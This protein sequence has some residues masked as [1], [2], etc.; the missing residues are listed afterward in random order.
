MIQRKKIM[1]ITID[2]ADAGGQILRTALF[3][4]TIKEKPF[5]ITNIRAKRSNPGLKPQHLCGVE[6]LVKITG[7][8]C[9]AKINDTSLIFYPGK[10]NS[11]KENIDI[12]TAGSITLLLQ[13]IIPVLICSKKISNF[14]ITGG[15]DVN[16]SPSMDYYIEVIAPAISQYAEIRLKILKRG[17][18]PKGSG[19][20]S[21]MIKPT[22]KFESL[23]YNNR[24]KLVQ[25]IGSTI[26]SKELANKEISERIKKSE[27]LHLKEI[28][29]TKSI[30]CAYSDT[31]SSGVITTLVAKYEN[32][33]IGSDVLGEIKVTS[34]EIGKKCANI[35]IER[36]NSSCVCDEHLCDNLIPFVGLFGGEIVTNKVTE[37][38]ITNINVTNQF[39]D[40]GKIILEEKE[41]KIIIKKI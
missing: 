18:Y 8:K 20:I 33:N 34:E 25:I 2:G 29:T 40:D 16:W 41:N 13:T 11:T 24:G 26:S 3:L 14:I 4:S 17:F 15:T 39:I 9:D 27:E 19:Q 32:V 38:I 21:I 23:N 7:A 35:L 22:K 5:T 36:I 1:M 30:A 31:F 10:C 12:G 6:S 28:D 37:H